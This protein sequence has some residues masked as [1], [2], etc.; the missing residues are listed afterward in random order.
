MHILGNSRY[1]RSPSFVHKRPSLHTSSLSS[2]LPSC[3]PHQISLALISMY[4]A[5]PLSGKQFK[6]YNRSV[7]GYEGVKP[8]GQIRPHWLMGLSQLFL[9]TITFGQRWRSWELISHNSWTAHH[10][11][12]LMSFER[13]VKEAL[14][15]FWYICSCSRRS[16][17]GHCT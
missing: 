9:L 13:F 17:T 10:R 11:L 6:S 12:H 8:C 14:Q 2:F 5:G 4:R 1:Y 3:R 15:A 16:V 7:N